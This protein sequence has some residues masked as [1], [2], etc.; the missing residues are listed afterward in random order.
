LLFIRALPQ[1]LTLKNS[2]FLTFLLSLKD[3]FKSFMLTH[4]YCSKFHSKIA[5]KF[6]LLALILTFT[7]TSNAQIS[8]VKIG[9]GFR[10]H[11][12]GMQAFKDVKQFY[13]DNRTWLD[14][15]FSEGAFLP[16]FEIGL[17]ANSNVWGFSMMH[18]YY[19]GART[20]AKGTNNGIE[21][22]RTLKTR[23]WGMEFVDAHWTPL[24]LGRMNIG[25]GVMPLGLGIFR[26]KT[27]LNDG[28]TYKPPYDYL[29]FTENNLIKAFHMYAQLHADV[30][31]VELGNDSAL[32]L[33]VFYTIGPKQEYDLY[34]LNKEINPTTYPLILK[35]TFLNMDNWG[36]K[37]LIN[38]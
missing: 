32:H 27:K 14:N 25:F 5:L 16:G 30:T 4:Y 20:N 34:Y 23:M 11:F 33:Q 24:H 29:E 31:A 15:G 38:I 17:E 19:T 37:L 26:I 18:L 2:T 10:S 7:S 3:L 6:S 21:Y 9:F 12:G 22:K 8:D 28:E 1:N 36:M 35:R 13:N